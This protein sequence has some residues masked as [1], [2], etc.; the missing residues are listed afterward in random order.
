MHDLLQ[1][2]RTTSAHAS[3]R[4]AEPDTELLT[5]ATQLVSDQDAYLGRSGE[6]IGRRVAD[7]QLE[8]FVV[9]HP[10]EAMRQQLQ[11]LTTEFIAIHDV[12]TASSARLLAAVAAAASCKLQR[13]V[14]RRQGYGVALATLQFVELTLS[15]Q[16]K[17][18]V[19][20]T[21]IDAD[22]Q[23]RQQL[24]HLLLAHSRLG[25]VMFG[26]L[27]A[28]ALASSLQPL[29][30]AI[31]TGPWPNRQLLLVPLA[32]AATLAAQAAALAGSSGVMVRTTPQAGRAEQ[33]WSYITGTW[34]LLAS[35][36]PRP[37]ASADQ[38]AGSAT[39][40]LRAPH[41]AVEPLAP[42]PMPVIAR[43]SAPPDARAELALWQEHVRCCAAIEGVRECGVFDVDAQ[44]LL[45]HFGTLRHAERLV[46]KAALLRAVVG[47][48]A[49]AVGA[50]A[51]GCEVSI[52]LAQHILLL[53][54]VPGQPRLAQYLLVD[55]RAERDTAALRA[56]LAQL[57]APG[58]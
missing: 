57:G 10:V 12:G 52:T 42:L 33:A 20:T 29:R 26:E 40:P 8:L 5:P 47:D 36:A 9:C 37:N 7:D 19:Y 41:L 39:A 55:R 30:E 27:P 16:R 54:P 17:L 25:V 21:Q 32:A 58:R 45:A 28:H 2:P 34:S 22:T 4:T 48:C 18:R 35:R 44:R 38:P 46:S 1:T 53:C 49:Q 3:A 24:A 11:Q 43:P 14:I 31:A 13:L 56:Q 15:S 50:S 23:T 51:T 6:D